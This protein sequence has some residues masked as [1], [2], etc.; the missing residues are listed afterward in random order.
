MFDLLMAIATVSLFTLLIALGLQ[1]AYDLGVEHTRE[2]WLKAEAERQATK[3][4]HA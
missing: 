3:V 1:W 2:E 4:P